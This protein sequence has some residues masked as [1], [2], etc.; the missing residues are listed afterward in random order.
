[1]R[2]ATPPALP[3]NPSIAVLAFENMGG[4]PERE[5]FADGLVQDAIANLSKIPSLFAIRAKLQLRLQMQ[6]DR[7]QERLTINQADKN[8]SFR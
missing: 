2:L 5:Y 1:M 4:D 7:R 6:D 8:W 3:N